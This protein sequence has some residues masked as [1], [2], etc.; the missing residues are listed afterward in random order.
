MAIKVIEKLK[1]QIIIQPVMSLIF[2]HGV[3]RQVFILSDGIF[4]KEASPWL[5]THHN[6]QQIVSQAIK[7]LN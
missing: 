4:L 1:L 6:P 7:G 3:V 5:I 2:Y